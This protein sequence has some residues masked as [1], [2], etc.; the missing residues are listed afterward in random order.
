[1]I[2]SY[3]NHRNVRL[4]TNGQESFKR[5]TQQIRQAKKSVHI[6][7]FIW[8]DDEIG[9]HVGRELLAAADRGV[10]VSISKDKLGSVFEKAE[11]NG[12]SFFHKD[13]NVRL[14]LKQKAI[15][16]FY[17]TLGE[18]ARCKQEPNALVSSILV[19]KNIHV[20]KDRIK[21]DHSKYFI[22][23][24]KALIIG[25]MNIETKAVHHDVNGTKWNDYIIEIT[26]KRSIY[27]L[28]AELNGVKQHDR[29]SWFEFVFN[30]KDKTRRFEIKPKILELL[31]S[32]RKTVYIE[33][34]YFG[35]T[36]ITNKIIEIANAGIRVTIL[37]PKR[38]N[39]QTDLNHKVM[40]HILTKTSGRANIYCC[41]NMIHAKMMYIDEKI[42]LMG[43][44]NLHRQTM[45][46]LSELDV[47]VHGEN[48]PFV[49]LMRESTEHRMS[50]S[51]RISDVAEIKVQ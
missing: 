33:M 51:E 1:M 48:L 39:L 24:D 22:F 36:D 4:L 21:G 40:K 26:G 13:F 31:S 42:M 5:I 20:D 41:R 12:Q 18:A 2:A 7:M 49:D 11:E 32:A 43:S 8:R 34:A 10:E 47:L 46:H 44:A 45:E 30:T 50:G 29:N 19:H 35:D 23:D 25:G 9:N 38:A 28:K 15:N 16:N 27:K 37:L 14:W 17:P 3:E 6:N